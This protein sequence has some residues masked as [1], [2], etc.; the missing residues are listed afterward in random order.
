MDTWYGYQSVIKTLFLESEL[1][2]FVEFV[3]PN[4][5]NVYKTKNSALASRL[6]PSHVKLK[7]P[8]EEGDN[9]YQRSLDLQKQLNQILDP[10]DKKMIASVNYEDGFYIPVYDD[11]SPV[12][13]HPRIQIQCHPHTLHRHHHVEGPSNP[14][15]HL[16]RQSHT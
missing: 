5:S 10:G 2:E 8:S 16:L 6:P 7:I 4:G 12:T 13:L 3:K 14:Q 1:Q 15:V 9:V 11:S